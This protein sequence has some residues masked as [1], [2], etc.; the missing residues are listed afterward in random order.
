ML[1]IDCQEL[2]WIISWIRGDIYHYLSHSVERKHITL[3]VLCKANIA[4]VT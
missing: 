3:S 2:Y 4:V 1:G